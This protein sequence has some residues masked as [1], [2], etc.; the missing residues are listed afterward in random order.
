MTPEF[1]KLL[2][3][4]EAVI[5]R[6]DGLVSIETDPRCW[7]YAASSELDDVPATTLRVEVLVDAGQVGVGL[8]DQQ[9]AVFV[10]PELVATAGTNPE[11]LEIPIVPGA[12]QVMFRNAGPDG[13]SARFRLVAMAVVARGDDSDFARQLWGAPDTDLRLGDPLPTQSGGTGEIAIQ[14]IRASDLSQVLGAPVEIAERPE[15]LLRDP[16]S[17]RMDPDDARLLR[18]IYAAIRP[19]RHLEFGTWEGFGVVLCADAAP[20][21]AITTVNLPDGESADDGTPMYSTDGVV[22]TDGGTRIGWRYRSAGL[23]DRVSQVLADTMTWHPALPD[24]YFDSVLIDGGHASPVV[25]SD[26]EL[27]LR[28]TRPGGLIMWHDFCPVPRVI[29]QSEATKGVVSAVASGLERWT[30]M[31]DSLAWVRPSFLLIGMR[32]ARPWSPPTP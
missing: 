27:A 30:P 16:L 23:E 14:A 32:S 2:P 28:L 25:T 5:R 22:A 4:N 31:L 29:Q 17:W 21:V 15:D 3:H 12:A 1:P 24:G 26:T 13:T 20:G 8:M 7:S 6:V 10:T 18:A 19:R 9:L 11:T